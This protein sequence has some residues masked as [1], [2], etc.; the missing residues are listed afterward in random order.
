M[1]AVEKLSDIFGR[2]EY[3]IKVEKKFQK[4]TKKNF[5]KQ[6]DEKYET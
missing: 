3:K 6:L 1:K 5:Q 2:V 4:E